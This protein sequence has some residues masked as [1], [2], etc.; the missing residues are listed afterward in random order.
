MLIYYQ[1]SAKKYEDYKIFFN[2]YLNFI[3]KFFTLIKF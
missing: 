2:L 1:K 3:L